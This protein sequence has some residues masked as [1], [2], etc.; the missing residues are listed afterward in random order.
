[1]ETKNKNN[2]VKCPTCGRIAEVRPCY[3]CSGRT[4]MSTFIK[5]KCIHCQGRG[6]IIYCSACETKKAQQQAAADQAVRDK[7]LRKNPF[8]PFYD[9][10]FKR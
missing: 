9:K 1:M 10:R 5:T 2:P 7:A 3:F 8:L 6:V 4:Q